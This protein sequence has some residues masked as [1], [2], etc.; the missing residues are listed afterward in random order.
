VLF[1]GLKVS[2]TYLHGIFDRTEPVIAFKTSKKTATAETFR[3]PVS[4][5]STTRR[6][7]SNVDG[8]MIEMNEL[9]SAA[10]RQNSRDDQQQ[11]FVQPADDDESTSSSLYSAGSGESSGNEL[12]TAS[13][14][15]RNVLPTNSLE[16][17]ADGYTQSADV[18]RRI[19]RK[20]S[21]PNIELANRGDRQKIRKV[22]SSCDTSWP[23]QTPKQLIHSDFAL[24]NEAVSTKHPFSINDCSLG[25]QCKRE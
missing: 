13:K 14:T 23:I 25:S 24:L 19:G 17:I 21:F 22:R 11:Q 9:N 6:E 2:V 20:Y 15:L 3:S 5:F 4:S 8:Q 18:N 7:T 12:L 16:L 1:F 10:M